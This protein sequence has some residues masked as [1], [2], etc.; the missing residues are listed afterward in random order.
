M[1][2]H[3]HQ[4]VLFFVRALSILSE[5]HTL[6]LYVTVLPVDNTCPWTLCPGCFH[7]GHWQWRGLV[8]GRQRR[9]PIQFLPAHIG[10]ESLSRY[11]NQSLESLDTGIKMVSYYCHSLFI[12]G[13]ETDQ[14][15][16]FIFTWVIEY[17]HFAFHTFVTG[18]PIFGLNLKGCG[19]HNKVFVNIHIMLIVLFCTFSQILWK[20]PVIIW[21]DCVVKLYAWWITWNKIFICPIICK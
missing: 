1:L 17:Y 7:Q 3:R 2:H 20:K 21:Q 6:Y 12:F 15:Y 10:P 8:P 9:V 5:H 4:S 11:P 13:H 16:P 19:E 14:I 18:F